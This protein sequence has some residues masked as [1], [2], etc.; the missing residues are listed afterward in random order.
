MT[1]RFGIKTLLVSLVVVI[2]LGSVGGV[3]VYWITAD[4]AFRS[5]GAASGGAGLG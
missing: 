3:G 1:A 5:I 4:P 2:F